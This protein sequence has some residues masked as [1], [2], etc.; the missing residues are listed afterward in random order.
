MLIRFIMRSLFRFLLNI[1]NR[2]KLKNKNFTIISSNCI[3]GFINHELKERFNSPTVN[4][5]FKPKDY[6]KFISNLRHYIQDCNLKE[7]ISLSKKYGYPV[8]NL[9][10]LTIYFQHYDSF[11]LAKEKWIERSKRINWDNLYFIMVER[12][13]CTFKQ[14]KEFDN[15]SFEHKV[16]F[17][18]KKYSN[19]PSSFYIEGSSKNGEVVDLLQYQNKI[20]LEFWIDNFDYVSF[21]NKKNLSKSKEN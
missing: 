17:T 18:A 13:G 2:K 5:F 8:G 12:D 16:I 11:S 9:D 10:D 4:L 1:R 7:N 20:S 19:I 14:I 6:L 21:L 15:M 3:G